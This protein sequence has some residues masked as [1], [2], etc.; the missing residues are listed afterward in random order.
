M[1]LVQRDETAPPQG[2]IMAGFGKL[3]RLELQKED[4]SEQRSGL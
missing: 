3:R 2:L 4:E 1:E